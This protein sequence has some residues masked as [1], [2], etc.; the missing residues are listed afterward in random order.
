M[1]V[2]AETF[3]PKASSNIASVTF[4]PSTDTL[5]VEFTSGDIY[6]YLNVPSTVYRSLTE[7]PSTGSFFYRHI[8]SVYPNV[9]Q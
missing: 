1:T 4:D 7:S 5:T 2:V 8:R 9:Q 3:I 6:D